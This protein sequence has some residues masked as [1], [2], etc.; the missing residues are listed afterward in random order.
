MKITT[1]MKRSCEFRDLRE[2]ETFL[3]YEDDASDV[4]MKTKLGGYNAVSLSTGAPITT[5]T[6]TVVFP[7]RC[8]LKV[9]GYGR[10]DRQ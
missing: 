2:G 7:V 10:E 5:D 8:E 6:E 1:E 3:L 9:V 4:R